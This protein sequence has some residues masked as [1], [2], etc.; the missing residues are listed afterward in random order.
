[1]PSTRRPGTSRLR[2]SRRRSSR[3]RASR[4]ST[5]RAALATVA[6][7]TLLSLAGGAAAMAAPLAAAKG[8]VPGAAVSKDGHERFHLTSKVATATSQHLQ[9]S[10]V[11]NARGQAVLGRK[12]SNGRVIWLV[13]GRGSV[14]LVTKLTSKSASPPNLTTCKFT[15]SAHGDYS[16]R[17]GKHRYADA[18]GTGTYVTRIRGTLK[19]KNGS[20][21]S[22]LSH[23]WQSTR[24]TGSMSW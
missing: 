24:M 19:R 4:L 23:Y 20:C 2:G 21:T 12:T 5:S 1:M 18:A 22:T 10:G 13:F 15:E 6:L 17:G 9:A 16:I 3:A 7:A 14:R 11:L 8:G